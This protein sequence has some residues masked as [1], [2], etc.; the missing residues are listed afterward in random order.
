MNQNETVQYDERLRI[1]RV[2]EDIYLLNDADDGTGYLVVGK[3]KALVV[4]TCNGE[5][6]YCAAIRSLT[7]LP[8]IVVNTHAHGDHTGG[9]R[10]FDS[11]LIGEAE[12]PY[13]NIKACPAQ[14]IR[15][16]DVIDLGGKTLEAISFPG[17]TPGGVCLLAREDRV[18]FT[19]DSVLG[20]TVWM[21][22]E[23]SV[24]ISTLKQ[25]LE[26]LNTYRDRFDVLLTGHGTKADDPAYIDSLIDACNVI[27]AGEPA[28]RFGTYEVWGRTMRCCYYTGEDG[29]PSPLVYPQWAVDGEPVMTAIRICELPDGRMVA[30][31]PGMWGDGKL[32]AFDTWLSAQPRDMTPRD[33]LSFDP[34]RQL[35]IWYY[36][37]ADGMDVPDGL[38]VVDFKGGLYL[39]AAGIDGADTGV[40]KRALDAYIEK[41]PVFE[42]EEARPAL[43]HVITPPSVAE[44]LGFSHM[45]YFF[46]IRIKPSAK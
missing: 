24:S 37:Y 11:A 2:L 44:A 28:D 31:Q 21:F 8:L 36:R 4:D 19:G 29:K 40:V 9:N 3:D 16:G 20:R 12:L 38:S 23:N 18:L 27:L 35:F 26:H 1:T 33:F 39:Y 10:F 14:V 46:P 17:H 30:S 34:E 43:G 25:S 5:Q 15:E 13:Y 7:Q 41:H 32:E 6:D 42:Y 45:D 22:M